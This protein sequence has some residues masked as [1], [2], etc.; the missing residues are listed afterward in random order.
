MPTR[1]APLA[2]ILAAAGLLAGTTGASATSGFGCYRVNVGPEDPLVIRDAP[3]ADAA[4]VA[5]YSWDDGPIIA[6]NAPGLRGEGRQPSLFE[7]WQAEFDVCTP[8]SLPVGARWCPVTVFDG[9]AAH[10]GWLKRR[11]VDASECP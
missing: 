11:F 5:T 3:R 2:L 10:P 7:V 4:A 6:L 1:R 8:P 9:D